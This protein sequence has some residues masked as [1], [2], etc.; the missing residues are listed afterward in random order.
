MNKHITL[1]FF[2]SD[3][4]IV[5]MYWER[6][7]NAIQETENKYGQLMWRVANNILGDSMDCEE[8]RNDAYFN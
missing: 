7:S 1:Q 2:A 6:N 4:Q 8:C 3:E 5:D